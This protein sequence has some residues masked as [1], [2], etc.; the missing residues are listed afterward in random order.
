MMWISPSEEPVHRRCVWL[1]H[2]GLVDTECDNEIL[3][4]REPGT[5]VEPHPNWQVGDIET[6][7]AGVPYKRLRMYG[8]YAQMTQIM[9]KA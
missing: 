9:S 6:V 3:S 7:E 2:S 5:P 4:Y 1:F 8:T